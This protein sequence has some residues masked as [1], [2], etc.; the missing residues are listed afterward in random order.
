MRIT[1]LG[2][3]G[4]GGVPM[5]GNIWGACDPTE[6][7]NRRTRPS[8]LVQDG[9][10]TVL[11]DTSPDV[12]QQLLTVDIRRLDAVLYTHAHADHTHGIDDLR[13]VNWLMEAPVDIWADRQTLAHLKDR[14]GYCFEP[15]MQG[16]GFAR[17][18]LTPHVIDGPVR[19]G[20]I[21]AV[22]FDQDH[23]LSRSLGFR[24]G[25][26]AYS[27]D[28]VRLDEDAFAVLDGVDTW[29]VDCVSMGPPHRVHAHWPVTLSWIERVRPRRAILTHMGHKMDYRTLLDRL[30]AGVE[31]GYDG[32]VIEI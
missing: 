28:V 31:P 8:I 11:V 9:E 5:I 10:T 13:A 19:V 25:P 14:F 22:P 2:C 3:G 30:P 4:S 26:V 7:R 27:T 21:E 6:P 17:P 23:G 20:R 18:V 1:I 32:L 24:F 12:R 29:I 16:E 15:R